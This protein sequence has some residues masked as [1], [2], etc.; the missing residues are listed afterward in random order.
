MSIIDTSSGK[1]KCGSTA[2]VPTV[3]VVLIGANI[4]N[5]PNYNAIGNFGV[6]PISSPL[7]IFIS[8]AKGHYTFTRHQSK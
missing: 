6:L 3:P 1:I 4:D 8:I 5:T 2:I 7:T